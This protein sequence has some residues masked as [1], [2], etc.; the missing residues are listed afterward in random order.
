MLNHGG[1]TRDPTAQRPDQQHRSADK[2]AQSRQT[3]FHK[4]VASGFLMR[5]QINAAVKRGR[6]LMLMRHDETNLPHIQPQFQRKIQHQRGD[7]RQHQQ[8]LSLFKYSHH[9]K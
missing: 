6:Y 4:R 2:Q 3:Q 8:H 5:L 9:K 1:Q 7:E